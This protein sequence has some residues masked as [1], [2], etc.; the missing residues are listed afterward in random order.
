MMTQD[1]Q[2][3]RLRQAWRDQEGDPEISADQ[4]RDCLKIRSSTILNAYLKETKT[5]MYSSLAL[6]ALGLMFISV[7]GISIWNA[8][9]LLLF[10]LLA[11]S[12]FVISRKRIQE[13]SAFDENVSMRESLIKKIALI[14]RYFDQGRLLGP[15]LGF[16]VIFSGMTL[17]KFMKFG[18]IAIRLDDIVV[19]T[20]SSAVIV[21]FT[22]VLLRVQTR[23]YL[24]PLFECLAQID[25]DP[26]ELKLKGPKSNFA[27]I[28]TIILT[29][30]VVVFL[31]AY[32]LKR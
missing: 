16:L 13:L 12:S 32:F 20:I 24:D 15:I 29:L 10:A 1:D 2:I 26:P 28:I 11:I 22:P 21:L 8:L 4:I 5:G 31:L 9:L 6:P 19:L 17:I 30:N 14:E 25:E 7:Y 27:L 23:R 18:R 3:E